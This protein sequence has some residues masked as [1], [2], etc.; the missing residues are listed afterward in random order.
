MLNHYIF[1]KLDPK[2]KHLHIFCDSC[3][4]QNKNYTLI[5]F[6]HY[7]VNVLQKLDTIKVV[8]PIRGHSFLECDRNMGLINQKYAAELPEDWVELI[9]NCRVKPSPFEVVEA[10]LPLFR[11]WTEFFS[12]FYTNK[13]PFATRP[14]REI[15]Y[16]KQHSRLVEHRAS[17]TGYWQL[18]PLISKQNLRMLNLEVHHYDD[19]SFDLPPQSRSDLV[20]VPKPK[21]DDLQH[22]KQFCGPKARE[23]YGRLPQE[24]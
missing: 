5:R 10:D 4:G 17:Y 23:F 20:P 22:L 14:I 11:K 8:F 24:H 9:R 18:S 12:K 13:C 7:V 6:C 3:S 2:V 1:T 21:Y 16:L 15:R 19:G